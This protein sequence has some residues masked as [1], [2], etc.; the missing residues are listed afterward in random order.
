MGKIRS[1]QSGCWKEI[2][3][4]YNVICTNAFFLLKPLYLI[5]VIL[6]LVVAFASIWGL[7]ITAKIFIFL[8]LLSWCIEIK[9][10]MPPLH[11]VNSEPSSLTLSQK[12][13][14]SPEV[15]SAICF[16]GPQYAIPQLCF[17]SAQNTITQVFQICQCAL[18]N[19]AIADTSAT[20][21]HSN[22]KK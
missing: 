12:K 22:D 13:N 14:W 3:Y 20:H 8:S 11:L 7:E 5:T 4:S 6:A 16:S 1:K 18:R 21:N 15:G 17:R 2:I 10:L 19:F 9:I